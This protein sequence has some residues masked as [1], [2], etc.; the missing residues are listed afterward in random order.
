MVI[1]SNKWKFQQL[2]KGWNVLIEE[3]PRQGM[4]V[5]ET[6]RLEV[7]DGREVA[8]QKS[9]V[10]TLSFFRDVWTEANIWT[11]WLTLHSKQVLYILIYFVILLCWASGQWAIN[12]SHCKGAKRNYCYGVLMCRNYVSSLVCVQEKT[13]TSIIP[14]LLNAFWQGWI[15]IKR[16]DY[17]YLYCVEIFTVLT[18][19]ELSPHCLRQRNWDL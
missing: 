5:K 11:N 8:E 13:D 19:A 14:T 6:Q 4:G 9:N 16:K 15:S 10:Y 12:G 7:A 17:N 18:A 1:K 2:Q 3:I